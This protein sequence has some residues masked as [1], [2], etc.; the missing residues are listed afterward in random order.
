MKI[1][2]KF[3]IGD[4]IYVIIQPP[5]YW[6]QTCEAC[7]GEGRVILLDA[8]WHQCPSCDGDGI[9]SYPLDA[10]QYVPLPNDE[11]NGAV[12]D[13]PEM[14]LI[15]F[16]RS[17]SNYA[18][19]VQGVRT[20]VFLDVLGGEHRVESYR[21]EGELTWWNGI[22]CFPTLDAAIDECKRREKEE[23]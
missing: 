3:S 1:E 22:T 14:A 18:R 20:D 11:Y 5:R 2:T 7:D 9:C 17:E 19:K 6:R 13:S 10:S 16:P 21:A 4:T 15:D 12:I 8:N 23:E